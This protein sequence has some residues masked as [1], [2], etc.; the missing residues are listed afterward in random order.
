MVISAAAPISPSIFTRRL[1]IKIGAANQNVP[2]NQTP[3]CFVGDLVTGPFMFFKL[4]LEQNNAD[5]V[6]FSLFYLMM[7]TI[8]SILTV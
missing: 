2:D 3:K 6:Q 8:F 1:L 4:M 5:R 7:S